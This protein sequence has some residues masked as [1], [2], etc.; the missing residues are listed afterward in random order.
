VIM[1]IMIPG[2]GSVQAVVYATAAGY[3]QLRYE[4]LPA[5]Q[6]PPNVGDMAVWYPGG[7]A[8]I[9]AAIPPSVQTPTA[10]P[11]QSA[12]PPFT[13]PTEPAM[14][15][16]RPMVDIEPA[17]RPAEREIPAATLPGIEA[18]TTTTTTP[19][20]PPP[21]VPQSRPVPDINK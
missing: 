7:P 5:G 1:T 19:I 15:A 4:P 12:V 20:A 13:A 17:S 14:P 9:P 3:V 11:P 2:G 10:A 6:S 21:T 18:P 16:T 8:V